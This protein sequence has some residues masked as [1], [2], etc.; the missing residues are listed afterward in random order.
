MECG[1][2]EVMVERVKKKKKKNEVHVK[3]GGHIGT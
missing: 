2:E 3:V 1:V